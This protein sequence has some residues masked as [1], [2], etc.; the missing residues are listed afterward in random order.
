MACMKVALPLGLLFC[1][2]QGFSGDSSGEVVAKHQ[3]LKLA[4][5][6]GVFDTEVGA[7]LL[8]FGI[9]NVEKERVDYAI[10]IPKLL[11]Y[12]SYNDPDAKIIGLK[13]YPKADWPKTAVDVSPFPGDDRDV[14]VDV[15]GFHLGIVSLVP[16]S[17]CF[18]Y[19]ISLVSGGFGSL[20]SNSQPGGVD[21]R[22]DG[23]IPVDSLQSP[24]D[25]RRVIKDGDRQ[26][27]ALFP[28]HVFGDLLLPLLCLYLSFEQEDPAWAGGRGG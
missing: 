13:E 19:H 7:P 21:V 4:A 6:E 2:L 3:P 14:G 12:L 17:T 23:P 15:G 11:S 9:P 20:S 25:Q 8:L 26:P 16:G 10:G 18:E 5:L 27:G 1:V 28:D 24:T 22:R